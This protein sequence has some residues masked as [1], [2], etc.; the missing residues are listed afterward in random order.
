MDADDRF[1]AIFAAHYRDVHRFALR[2]TDA[3]EAEEVA[4]ETSS[5][6]SASR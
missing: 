3:E 1:E 6:S 2:R 4:N 5:A